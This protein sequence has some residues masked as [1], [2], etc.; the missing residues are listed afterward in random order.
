MKAVMPKDDAEDAMR[1]DEMRLLHWECNK[2]QVQQQH[3]SKRRARRSSKCCMANAIVKQWPHKGGVRGG[4]PGSRCSSWLPAPLGH[5]PRHFASSLG[6][7][8]A[9][10][11]ANRKQ[12]LRTEQQRF[13]VASDNCTGRKTGYLQDIPEIF[14][15]VFQNNLLL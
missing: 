10:I 11:T 2:S 9:L 7:A 13:G 8:S 6:P 3:C 4:G 5:N 1:S 15:K 12:L 14:L